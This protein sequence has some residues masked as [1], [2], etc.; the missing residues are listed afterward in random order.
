[1]AQILQPKQ[2][3][4]ES[5]KSKKKKGK[6]TP[7]DSKYCGK[8]RMDRRDAHADDLSLTQFSPSSVDAFHAGVSIVSRI[9]PNRFS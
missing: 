2:K 9:V 8:S 7:L 1:M 3:K 5:K 6:A 4:K